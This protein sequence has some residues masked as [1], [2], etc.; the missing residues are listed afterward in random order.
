MKFMEC[1]LYGS[2]SVPHPPEFNTSVSHKKGH[3]FSA[4]KIL[5]FNTPLSSTQK[6]LSVLNWGVL[7]WNWG[8]CETEGCV[9]FGVNSRG[10]W[11]WG[12]LVSNRGVF[13]GEK[14]GP[15]VEL[16]CRN[17][18]VVLNWGVFFL[19]FQLIIVF[20]AFYRNKDGTFF[21]LNSDHLVRHNSNQ[22]E[23]SHTSDKT[24]HDILPL[25]SQR[26]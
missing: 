22:R 21:T 9:V 13:G 14:V 20:M 4:P 17:K 23:L 12:V 5:Q 25:P 19:Y 11:N 1:F 10:R 24:H 15:C 26:K 3:S 18:R 2:P 6:P 8:M 16:L 7:V